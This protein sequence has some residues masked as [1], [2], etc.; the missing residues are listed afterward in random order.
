MIT[1]S[2]GAHLKSA[3]EEDGTIEAIVATYDKDSV[4]DKI[5]PGAFEKS[6]A[7]WAESGK[8]IPFIWSHQHDN[9]D[10]YLGEILEAKETDDG[11]WVKAKV[12]MD[13]PPA[14]RVY[15]LMKTG[16]VSQF[17]F[18]YDVE[19]GEMVKAKSAGEGDYY[20]LRQLKIFE[21]GPCLIGANQNTR[22]LGAKRA[23]I[24]NSE[25][26][27]DD[28]ATAIRVIERVYG[29]IEEKGYAPSKDGTTGQSDKRDDH[30]GKRD[31]Q[32]VSL[33][34]VLH[35]LIELEAE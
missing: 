29:I 30:D 2:F 31:D 1:K 22:L 14:K 12:D 15:D 16:K 13:H 5:A 23:Q 18:A 20:E 21:A 11:L 8:N 26:T 19:D 32:N 9:P 4:G 25:I 10:A 17:S 33:S 3:S 34:S 27:A 28:M 6:L 24:V 7:A 35:R